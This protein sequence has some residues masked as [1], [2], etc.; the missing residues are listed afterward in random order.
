MVNITDGTNHIASVA[1]LH[2]RTSSKAVGLGKFLPPRTEIYY[3]IFGN[4]PRVYMRFNTYNAACVNLVKLMKSRLH[5]YIGGLGGVR[6]RTEEDIKL[7]ATRALVLA[8]D[9]ITDKKMTRK[10]RGDPLLD[11][12]CEPGNPDDVEDNCGAADARDLH[13]KICP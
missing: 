2:E 6:Y 10:E 1:C 7:Q 5:V 4:D 3:W 9:S 11:P 12:E 8:R 13:Q